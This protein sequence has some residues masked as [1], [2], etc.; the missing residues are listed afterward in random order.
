MEH[1][2]EDLPPPGLDGTYRGSCALC[3]RGTDTAIG[4]AGEAEWIVAFFN[5]Q[6]DI[7]DD[8]ALIML[9]S[10]TN[11]DEGMVPPGVFSIV[12]RICRDCGR[13]KKL[14]VGPFPGAVPH[15]SQ[16]FGVDDGQHR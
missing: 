9:S 4:L 1:D 12:V 7:P 16:G 11:C 6:M 13:E 5:V 2:L 10:A 8:Q 3:L 15:Y 14:Q